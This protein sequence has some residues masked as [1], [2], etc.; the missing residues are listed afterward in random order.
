MRQL[1]ALDL[2]GVTGC[3]AVPL[4]EVVHYLYQGLTFDRTSIYLEDELIPTPF[5]TRGAAPKAAKRA[6]SASFISPIAQA[7]PPKNSREQ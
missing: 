3:L 1:I 5:Q 4:A 2:T 7:E 6:G